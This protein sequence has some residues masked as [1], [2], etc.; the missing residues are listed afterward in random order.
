MRVIGWGATD[1]GRKRNHN[2]DSFLCNNDVALYAVADGMGGHLGGER[3]SRMAV[4]ILEREIVQVLKNGAMDAA[5][6]AA[7]PG[8]P[9][10]VAALLRKAVV[11]ADPTSTKKQPP[12]PSWRA[13][14]RR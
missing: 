1:V 11:E 4:E 9:N 12:I 5:R 14:A 6:L 2:E 10:P 3:A 13:W 7:A 8:T